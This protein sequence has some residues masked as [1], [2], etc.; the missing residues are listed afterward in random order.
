MTTDWRK[1]VLAARPG[2]TRCTLCHTR[3]GEFWSCCG[4][5]TDGSSGAGCLHDEDNSFP[6]CG[7]CG[8]RRGWWEE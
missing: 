7:P 6:V 1:K 2:Y 5:P 4:A 3:D 8:A